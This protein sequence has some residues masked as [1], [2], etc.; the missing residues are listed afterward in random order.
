VT[1][2]YANS[3]AYSS[4]KLYQLKVLAQTSPKMFVC[5]QNFFSVREVLFSSPRSRYAG[6]VFQCDLICE[7]VLKTEQDF[8]A[9]DSTPAVKTYNL[10]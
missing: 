10:A 9:V 8:L 7:L 5:G 1:L 3:L 2:R 6:F 4:V